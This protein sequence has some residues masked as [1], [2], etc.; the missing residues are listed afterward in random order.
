MGTQTVRMRCHDAVMDIVLVPGLWL[1]KATWDLV[2]PPLE[3]EGHLVAALT[4]PGLESTESDRSAIGLEDQ[5]NAVVNTIDAAT[6][7]VLV[8]GHSMGC[9][10]AS[11]AVDRRVEAVAGAVYVGGWPCADGVPLCQG[12]ATDGPDLPMPHISEFEG[13]DLRDFTEADKQAFAAAAIPSPARLAT[14]VV[15]LT[16]ARRYDV[17]VT[18]VC[19]EY[20]ADDVRDW[21]EANEAP[22]RELAKY[23]EVSYVDLPTSHWPQVTRP[24][25]LS[26]ELLKVAGSL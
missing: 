9:G 5:V 18:M 23:R 12:F 2:A 16:D 17:P 25:E 13:P 11:I 22:V 7:P 14:D 6:G 26:K 8:V 20:S 1:T 4:L 24:A 21:I 15:T 10:I 19:P 3:A